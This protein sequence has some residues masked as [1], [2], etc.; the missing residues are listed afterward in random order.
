[1]TESTLKDRSSIADEASLRANN[2]KKTATDRKSFVAYFDFFAPTPEYI[3]QAKLVADRMLERNERLNSYLKVDKPENPS[4]KDVLN[5][6]DMPNGK[7][8]SVDPTLQEQKQTFFELLEQM[9]AEVDQLKR[10]IAKNPELATLHMVGFNPTTTVLKSVREAVW[11]IYNATGKF[12]GRNSTEALKADTRNA[13]PMLIPDLQAYKQSTHNDI[14][15][16]I[17]TEISPRVDADMRPMALSM[18]SYRIPN[19]PKADDLIIKRV[20]AAMANYRR[21]SMAGKVSD[22]MRAR[23]KKKNVS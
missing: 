17:T 18:E 6:E 15:N 10:L 19:L 4:K 8:V 16:W 23:R 2:I 3:Q 21:S 12:I 9:Q 20:Y 13:I 14:A 11:S 1:M 7:L 22:L 5:P